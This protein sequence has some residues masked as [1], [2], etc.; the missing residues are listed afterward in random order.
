VLALGSPTFPIER[1]SYDAW[2]STYE[3]KS[4]YGIDYLYAGPLFIHQMSHIWL[5]LRGIRDDFMRAYDSDYFENSR[6]AAYVQQR[7]AIENP[8]GFPDYGRCAGALPRAMAQARRRARS[9][10]SSASSTT[11]SPVVRRTGR[12]MVRSRH[13]PW[14]LRCRSRL[15]SCYP[16]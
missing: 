3:W 15:R 10:A 9:T 8:L 14:P 11:T 5:D 7:Y 16:A 2:A 6:R 13:G 4:I 1:D 12:T